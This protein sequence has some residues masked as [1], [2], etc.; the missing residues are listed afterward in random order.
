MEDEKLKWGCIGGRGEYG[1]PGGS[2]VKALTAK[3]ETWETRVRSLGQEDPLEVEMAT[4]SRME[5]SMDREA[6]WASAH[7]VTKSWT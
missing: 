4:H 5:N 2:V 6:R 1:F 3:Q 7:G